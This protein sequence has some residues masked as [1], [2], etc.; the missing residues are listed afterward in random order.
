MVPVLVHWH[1]CLYVCDFERKKIVVLDPK[2]MQIGKTKMENKHK[3]TIKL[4]QT[5][6]K[7]CYEIMC[8]DNNSNNLDTWKSEYIIQYGVQVDR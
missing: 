8:N 4:I 7:E 2:G 6:M 5:G 1:W 3:K